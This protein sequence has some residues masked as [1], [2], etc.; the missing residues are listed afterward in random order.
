MYSSDAKATT[1]T[2]SGEIFAGP[3]RVAQILYSGGLVA[4]SIRI[5]DDGATGDILLDVATIGGVQQLD[6]SRTPFY[7]K[8]NIYVE[9]TDVVSCTVVHI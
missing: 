5:R 7:C 4:G 1:L 9:L 2:A 6:F 3:G 8:T